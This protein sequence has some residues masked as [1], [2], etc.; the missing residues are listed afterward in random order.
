M[1]SEMIWIMKGESFPWPGPCI[2]IRPAHSFSSWLKKRLIWMEEYAAFGKI[3]E[4]MEEADK[5]VSVE[6]D[7]N[8]CPR[9]PQ[10]IR[11]IRVMEE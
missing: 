7:W 8:D 4:G 9:V 6:R 10:V 1:V 2:P 11:S 3:T 5:I